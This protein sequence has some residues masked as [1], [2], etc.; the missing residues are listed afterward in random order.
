MN[1]LKNQDFTA[2]YDIIK[3][4]TEV[5]IERDLSLEEFAAMTNLSRRTVTNLYMGKHN[6]RL[7]TLCK[8]AEGMGMDMKI[9]FVPKNGE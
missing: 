6:P 7:T 9:R 3:A 8:L 1:Q 4:M 5:L 2:D